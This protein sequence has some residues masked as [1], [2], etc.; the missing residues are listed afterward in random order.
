VLALLMLLSGASYFGMVRQNR[1]L[2]NMV[3]VRA[4]H[5]QA[6]AGVAAGLRY[7]HANIYQ[8]LAWTN[9]SFAKP[10]L[11]ALAAAIGTRHVRLDQEIGALAA[12]AEPLERTLLEA[13]AASLVAYRKSV[14]E[15]IEL[16]QVDVSIAANAMGKAEQQFVALNTQLQQLAALEQQLSERA[17][18]DAKAEFGAL[19]AGVALLVL[20]SIGL[21][22]AVTVLVRRSM[23]GDI[24]AIA[25]VVTALSEGRLAGSVPSEGRDEIADA[26]RALGLSIDQLRRTMQAVQSSVRSI[27][28]AAQEIATGNA[29]LSARTELQAA[30]LQ[31][32]ASTMESLALAVKGNAEQARQASELACGAQ[33][34][35]DSGGQAVRRV[36]TSM[37]SIRSS[38]HQVV[39]IIGVID[40]IA[41]QTNILALN[42]AVEAARAGE[43]G[44]GFAVVAAEVRALAQRSASAAREIKLL[45]AASSATIDGGSAAV[46]EAGSSMLELV[47]AI[48]Q[49]N[50]IVLHMSV[51]NSKHAGSL[52]EVNQAIGKMDGMTQQNAALVEQA[53]AAAESLHAQTVRLSAAV[54]VFQFDGDA[55]TRP[56]PDRPQERRRP[57]SAMRPAR[58]AVDARA[59]PAKRRAVSSR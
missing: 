3:Q 7:A 17:Y 53:A 51:A 44:R 10:R 43:H 15:T 16:A 49:V 19:V 21:S 24:R 54:S 39:E 23:L 2:E 6:A 52:A 20:L 18:A 57:G 26:S 1:T 33:A 37:D 32:T 40:A 11:D 46:A 50:Q 59:A 14:Q 36:V 5:M 9:G 42:A 31:H 47:A 4:V 41:F 45:I 12:T 30:S 25:R 28:T 58:A 22:L 13:S 27:D 48:G 55:A 35:A 34:L 38:S 56:A 29:D 8:L